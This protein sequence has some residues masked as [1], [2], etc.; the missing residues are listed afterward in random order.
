[1]SDAA[2]GDRGHERG[3]KQRD[4][5]RRRARRETDSQPRE[6]PETP[7]ER[8]EGEEA[9]VD[10]RGSETAPQRPWWKRVFGG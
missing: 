9:W 2:G 6:S 10:A 8:P 4:E 3:G 7:L 1:M 5:L